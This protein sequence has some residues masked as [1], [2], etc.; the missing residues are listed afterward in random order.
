[1]HGVTVEA[2]HFTGRD[3][4]QNM[5][6]HIHKRNTEE[7]ETA[8]EIGFEPV[9]KCM[10]LTTVHAVTEI[11]HYIAFCIKVKPGKTGPSVRSTEREHKQH[12]SNSSADA[13]LQQGVTAKQ[14][15]G[16]M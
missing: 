5:A 4:Q 16:Q 10:A 7:R 6:E 9:L 1:M 14:D 15:A 3:L 11:A 13:P 12:S 2:D 8:K